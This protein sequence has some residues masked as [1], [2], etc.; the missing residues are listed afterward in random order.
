V[1]VGVVLD[2]PAEQDSRFSPRIASWLACRWS[3]PDRGLD[4]GL[5]AVP[6]RISIA[7]R[8]LGRLVVVDE[9][10]AHRDARLPGR[11][12]HTAVH[13]Q[14]PLVQTRPYSTCGDAPGST[15]LTPRAIR[16]CAY[17]PTTSDTRMCAASRS[18]TV[19]CP[20][21]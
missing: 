14:G 11:E 19:S 20:G 12:L 8:D 15:A 16:D 18:R 2:Q 4:R 17:V 5:P 10:R 21:G 7:L 6:C 1:G 13:G 3:G 9:V